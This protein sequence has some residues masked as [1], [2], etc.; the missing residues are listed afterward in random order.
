MKSGMTFKLF[1]DYTYYF[2]IFF[3]NDMADNVARV[4]DGMTYVAADVAT[5]IGE[6]VTLSLPNQH[7]VA[8]KYQF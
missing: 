4:T 6:C 1:R 7:F 5:Y 8:D 3:K 2:F